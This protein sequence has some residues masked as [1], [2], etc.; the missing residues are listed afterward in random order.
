[1]SNENH[2]YMFSII[3]QIEISEYSISNIL[4]GIMVDVFRYIVFTVVG[5]GKCYECDL[6]RNAY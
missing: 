4:V 1:M 3:T 6:S 2:L 5:D